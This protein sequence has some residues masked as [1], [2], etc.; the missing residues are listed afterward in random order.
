MLAVASD[1][2]FKSHPFYVESGAENHGLQLITYIVFKS[3]LFISFCA[4]KYEKMNLWKLG[5]HNK[6][7]NVILFQNLWTKSML[8]IFSLLQIS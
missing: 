8:F 4:D 7:N 5:L 6:L 2:L 1:R 3:D